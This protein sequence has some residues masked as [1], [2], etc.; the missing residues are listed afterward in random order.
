MARSATLWLTQPSRYAAIPRNRARLV[1]ALLAALL[2]A[3][4]TAPWSS[5]PPASTPEASRSGDDRRDVLLYESIVAG[6]RHGGQYYAVAA[7]ELRQ[8]NYPLRPFITFRLPT[9]AVVQAQLPP[10]ALPI[11]LY[12]LAA[13]T[14]LAW[15]ARFAELLRG[16]RARVIGL[17][18]LAG[19]LAVFVQ[20]DLW[21]FHEVWAGLLVALSLARRK[22]GRWIDAAA[23][24]LVAALVR[25]T[26]AIY[27]ILMAA[28]AW[29]DG[30][31]R[32]AL[33][34]VLALAL[35]GVALGFHAAAVARVVTPL[36]TVSPGWSGL[37]GFGFFV[38]S[39]A[40][41]TALMIMPGWLQAVLVALALFGWTAL[42]DP[43]G[44]RAASLFF[45]FALLLALF[46][47]ADTFYW[48]MVVAPPFLVGLAF[49]PDAARELVASALDRRR[50]RVQIV[51]R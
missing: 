16:W 12:L 27:L 22:P 20:G 44:A 7:Q 18:L 3:S 13:S 47:R 34:W 38:N 41:T 42:R 35:F 40:A 23:I 32:E 36:D 29:R 25:E 30:A 9:L 33:G 11:S 28:W 49:V 8:G 24:G 14:A 17:A 39:I 50:L 2:L 6:I 26:A 5:A 1:L 37:L 21:P 43:L 31:R 19:G 48:A 4:M 51:S 15:F 10:I 45:A 46:A